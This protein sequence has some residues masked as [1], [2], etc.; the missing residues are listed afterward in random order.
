M[1]AK[2]DSQ[3]PETR[4]EDALVRLVK[5]GREMRKALASRD[6]EAVLALAEDQERVLEEAHE[7]L[8]C[9]GAGISRLA[10][11]VRELHAVNQLNAEILRDE[12]E[13][14]RFLMAAYSGGGAPV[15]TADGQVG[16]GAGPLVVN[17]V[18]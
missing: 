7:A 8:N 13:T 2:T 14:A 9:S 18:G 5:L 3:A 15:Y 11:L 17:S 12:L 4:A 6:T 16:G 10:E 1:T